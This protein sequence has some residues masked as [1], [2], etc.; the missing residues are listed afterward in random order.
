VQ[1]EVGLDGSVQNLNGASAAALSAFPSP[2]TPCADLGCFEALVRARADAQNTVVLALTNA[3]FAPFWHNLRCSMERLNVSRHAIVIGTDADACEAA[4]SATVPCVIGSRV[5]WDE[6]VGGNGADDATRRAAPLSQSAEKHG[7]V[8]YARLM[9]IKAR[10]ALAALRLGFNLVFTDTDVVW[11]RDPLRELHAELSAQPEVDVLIQ[12]DHDETNAAACTRHEDC[13]RSAWCDL[14]A[15]VC[16][17]EVCGGFYLLRST[18]PAVALLEN[19]F[20]RMA[21][22]R[23]NVD[24]RVG[25]QPALNVVLRRTTGLTYRILPR[26]LYPNGRAYFERQI[27]PS[28]RRQPVIVHNNWIAGFGPKVERFRQGGLW[29]LGDGASETEGA[30]GGGVHP[31]GAAVA[32]GGRAEHGAER[33]ETSITSCIETALNRPAA[34]VN[35]AES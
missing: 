24:A 16:E 6:G 2:T 33:A 11:L 28:R 14:A 29:L 12:S 35:R 3:G 26:E 25:E 15:G 22:Q 5:L 8:E 18:R 21:W 31:P 32:R 13:A 1:L 19:L 10:P 27:W 17:A 7:T 34:L 20:D 4:A 9:H 30:Q 23:A